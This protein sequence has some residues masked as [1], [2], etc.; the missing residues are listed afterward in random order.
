MYFF[1]DSC[2]YEFITE[3]DMEKMRRIPLFVPHTLL[4]D[5]VVPGEIYELVLTV[6]KGGALQDTV[7][8]ICI[9]ALGSNRED[10]TQDPHALNILTEFLRLAQLPVLPGSQKTGS[11]AIRFPA[12]LSTTGRQ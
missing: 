4:M 9:A 6:L 10:G 8:E 12:C 1:P 11:G 5:E 7:A 2:F 3:A